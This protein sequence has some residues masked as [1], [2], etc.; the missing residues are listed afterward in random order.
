MRDRARARV[1]AGFSASL[2]VPAESSDSI[3]CDGARPPGPMKMQGT[4]GA[5][6]TLS[7]GGGVLADGVNVF[8]EEPPQLESLA[9]VSVGI[10]PASTRIEHLRRD[11]GH[12]IGNVQAENRFDMGWHIAEPSFDHRAHDR[13]RMRDRHPLAH[14][15]G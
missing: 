6:A 13:A 10:R 15:I 8:L 14:A 7:G 1:D 5:P 11:T 9:I 3:G 2:G 12:L 4:S